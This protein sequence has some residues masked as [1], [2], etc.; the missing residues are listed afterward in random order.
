VAPPDRYSSS[1]GGSSPNQE[2]PPYMMCRLAVGVEPP[3]GFWKN[4]ETSMEQCGM[5]SNRGK[6]M[7]SSY[8]SI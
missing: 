5:T 1:P 6:I 2:Q 7:Q 3:G 4:P 8:S